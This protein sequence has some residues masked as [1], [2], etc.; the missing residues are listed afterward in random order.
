M[1]FLASNPVFQQYR[2][3]EGK[4][5]PSSETSEEDSESVDLHVFKELNPQIKC[6][7][8]PLGDEER[9]LRPSLDE[10]QIS[11]GEKSSSFVARDPLREKNLTI[12]GD[13][14]GGTT[15]KER[16]SAL[17]DS[18]ESSHKCDLT[19]PEKVA[20]CPSENNCS[21][22]V[23]MSAVKEKQRLQ[24]D[25][26]R[27]LPTDSD[28]RRMR[29][30]SFWEAI[31]LLRSNPDAWKSCIPPNAVAKKKKKF[32]L[33]WLSCY[34]TE[35]SER[36]NFSINLSA[37]LQKDPI[38]LEDILFTYGIIKVPF[39]HDVLLHR[40]MLFTIYQSVVYPRTVI[41]WRKRREKY[42]RGGSPF[43]ASDVRME[44]GSDPP[45]GPCKVVWDTV[46]FQG[47]D[48]ATDLRSTGM[49]GLLQLLYLIDFY[50]SLNAQ[51][52][53]LCQGKYYPDSQLGGE[54]PYVLVSF[55]LTEVVVN[56]LSK[57]F[58]D[59]GIVSMR[60]G[61]NTVDIYARRCVG[62][63]STNV[64]Q[65]SP[66]VPKRTAINANVSCDGHCKFSSAE[67]TLASQ[68]PAITVICDF[69]VGCVY[70]F[71]QEWL[72]RA[73]ATTTRKLSIADFPVIKQTL[74]ERWG[75]EQ[76]K[77]SVMM[78]TAKAR[79]VSPSLFL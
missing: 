14:T 74:A 62:G 49:L 13:E 28:H 32:F 78:S 46:G 73:K 21:W 65:N 34:T 56:A 10:S 58:F 7:S 22:L 41:P 27:G 37:S 66:A 79:Y 1:S 48:P 25:E 12:D 4:A 77:R 54:L 42:D 24:V 9:Q 61:N 16:N 55:N 26:D 43:T 60:N 31:V 17:D 53:S 63:N 5:E 6:H 33:S 52:W 76:K 70:E 75:N 57:G 71:I 67:A 20:A 2:D 38:I 44:N 11:R 50:P 68:Y 23:S 51:F 72:K 45:M 39:S 40:G 18:P 69:Y 36:A 35:T 47:A 30:L 3:E 64:P 59:N 29:A 15:L 8:S 19:N